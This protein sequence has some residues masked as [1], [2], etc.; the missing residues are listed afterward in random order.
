M[1]PS[2]NGTIFEAKTFCEECTCGS[3]MDQ[4]L[5]CHEKQFLLEGSNVD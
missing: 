5:E 4:N 3:P 1:K 2:A